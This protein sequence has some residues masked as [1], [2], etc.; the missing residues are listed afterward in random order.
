MGL[1]RILTLGLL[2][3]VLASGIAQAGEGKFSAEV[4][5]DVYWVAADHDSAIEDINGLWLRR[6]NVT[7]DYKFDEAFSSRVRLEAQTPG[8]FVSTEIMLAFIKDAWVKWTTGNQNVLVGLSPTPTLSMVEE[9]WGY[10][11]L[12]KTPAE[13]QRLASSRDM[14]LAAVGSFDSG[15]KFGYHAMAGNGSGQVGES[16][17]K[18]KGYLGFRFRPTDAW[19]VEAY[20]DYEDRVDSG[21]RTTYHGLLGYKVENFRSGVQYIRQLRKETGDDVELRV[22]SAWV[23]GEISDNV[24]LFGRVD[25][26]FDANPEGDRIAYIP[27]DPTAPNTFVLAGLDW[28]VRDTVGFSPNVEVVVYDEPDAGGPTPDTDVIPRLTFHLTF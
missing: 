22:L 23:T 5:G 28:W 21:D 1:K 26:N 2:A 17:A 13:L 15:K 27:F 14:G 11:Y 18:K 12:E 3:L 25:R 20:A 16:N 24:W 4:F 10:R 8:D 6:I 9:I 19:A 7:H